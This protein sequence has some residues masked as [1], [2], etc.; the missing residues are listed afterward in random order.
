MGIFPLTWDMSIVD[1]EIMSSNHDESHKS[2]VN[3]ST[4]G[5]RDYINQSVLHE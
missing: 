4:A 3:T 2:E 1:L 5:S